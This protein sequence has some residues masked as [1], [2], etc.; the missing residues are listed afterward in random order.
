MPRGLALLGL[1]YSGMTVWD[2][3]FIHPISSAEWQAHLGLRVPRAPAVFEWRW[4]S[5]F[6]RLFSHP[7]P[8]VLDLPRSHSF[9]GLGA[10][11]PCF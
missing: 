1:D 5:Q 9:S 4:C 8:S 10:A 3:A 6:A 11:T 2:E 7:L